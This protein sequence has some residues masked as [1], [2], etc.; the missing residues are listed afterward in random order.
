M[1]I[2]WH[3]CRS[4]D[5]RKLERLQERA[6]RAIYCD[7]TS[8][9]E[10]LLEKARLPTLCNRRLQDMAIFM[11]KVKTNLVPLYIS[12]LFSCDMTRYNLRNTDDFSLPRCNTVTY[13]RHSLRYM[14]S[15]IWSKLYKSI[16]MADSLTAF[17]NQVRV[18]DLSNVMSR[19][20]CEN[21][22]LCKTLFLLILYC[23]YIVFK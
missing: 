6:L 4:S 23:L 22:K 11:Y 15:Y 1:N 8:T 14:G 18:L 2:V 17:K 9:Y 7:R 19:N 13:G 12:D 3:H 20:N 16:K 5:E 21:C 10:A